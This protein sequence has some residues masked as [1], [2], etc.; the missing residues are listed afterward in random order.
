MP[1]PNFSVEK[2]EL[3][4]IDTVAQIYPMFSRIPYVVFVRGILGC[5]V[6]YV[7]FPLLLYYLVHSMH[8]LRFVIQSLAF[9]RGFV[10]SA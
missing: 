7:V 2:G 4:G 3:I 9:W 8:E 1:R 5:W 10:V 6:L